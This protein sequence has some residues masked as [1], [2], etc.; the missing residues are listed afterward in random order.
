MPDLGQIFKA[1]KGGNVSEI[2]S[3]VKEFGL[4]IVDGKLFAKDKEYAAA[5]AVYFDMIQ[6]IRKIG[7]NSVYGAVTNAGSIFFDQRLGQ[8]CTLSG[9]CTTRHMG[10]TINQTSGYDYSLGKSIVYGDTDSCYF[11]IPDE[12][13]KTMTKDHF[14]KYADNIADTVNASFADFYAKTFNAKKG[15]KGVIKAGREICA[16]SALFIKKKRY[17]ALIYTDDSNKRYDRDGKKGKLKIMGLEIKRSDCPEWVQD[18]LTD[19]LENLLAYKYDE[20]QI[21]TFI[22]NWR[23]EFVEKTPWELGTPKR[24]NKLAF[25]TKAFNENRKG[26]T[27]P[28]HVRA[29]INWNRMCEM[30]L[31]NSSMRILDGQKTIVCT[32]KHNTFGIVTIA[33]PIDQQFLPD[34]FK[35]L[36]FDVDVMVKANVDNK[37]KNIFGILGWDL[38]RLQT[39]EKVEELFEWE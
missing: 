15:V 22:R 34:W 28:G 25:Y 10:S 29:A 26:I 18:K 38:H 13:K 36:N 6:L 9:R 19:T 5:Q 32:L 17:A 31:D 4:E 37:I 16:E 7:L 35:K 12:A 3:I 39:N 33:Y 8:S 20:D 23:T 21:I 14:I 11:T 24:V 30:A 2:A 27:I 1:I